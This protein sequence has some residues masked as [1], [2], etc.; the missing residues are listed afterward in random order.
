MAAPPIRIGLLGASRIARGAIIGPANE[1]G[2]ATVTRVAASDR[3]RALAYADEYGIPDVEKDYEALVASDTVDLV[4]NA[5]PP[6]GHCVWTL[7]ALAN[8]KH[9]LCE[10]PFAMNAD[11]AKRM[12]EAASDAPGVLVEAFHYRFHPAFERLLALVDAGSVGRIRRLDAYFNVT[13]PYREGE[14]RHTL[15][16]GGGALMDLGCYSL[17]WLRSIMRAE[18]AVLSAAAVEERAGVDVSMRASLDFDGVPA[19]IA[20]S[21]AEGLPPGHKAALTIEGERGRLEMV[22]PLAPHTGHE[23][24]LDTDEIKT[25]ESV[26][27]HSTYRHQ[28]EAVL[29]V[30]S[31]SADAVTGGADAVGNMRAIDA[32]YRAAGMLPRGKSV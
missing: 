9:V 8:G 22:N 31:G 12:V 23:I 20:C 13:I 25:T 29:D 30:I 7:A 27:G 17:H 11:E 10:K 1:I 19:E 3:E 18:P 21:M 6:S 14:L 16:V 32:I 15:E 26:D 4:Y 24:R 28:L 5:L 2:G